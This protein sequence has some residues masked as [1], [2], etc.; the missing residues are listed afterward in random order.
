MRIEEGRRK[1]EG[2]RGTDEVGRRKEEVGRRRGCRDCGCV[3]CVGGEYIGTAEGSTWVRKAIQSIRRLS[4]DT[5]TCRMRFLCLNSCRLHSGPHTTPH[6][7]HTHTLPHLSLSLSNC[8]HS[9][10]P[11]THT[12]LGGYP[13][14][15]PSLLYLGCEAAPVVRGAV[16]V[17]V[18]DARVDQVKEYVV[19]AGGAAVH[20]LRLELQRVSCGVC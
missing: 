20:A 10:T 15:Y 11:N 3:V 5:C 16:E 14:G 9:H 6:S 7:S 8:P 13:S 1:E 17:G 19:V 18:A 2:G 4:I 12:L